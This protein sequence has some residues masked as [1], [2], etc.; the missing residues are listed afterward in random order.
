MTVAPQA[1]ER[2]FGDELSRIRESLS[3]WEFRVPQ[4]RASWDDLDHAF[5]KSVADLASLRMRGAGEH[6]Q[7]PAAGMPWFMAVFG[8][9]TLITCLQTLL[10]GPELAQSALRTL[11]EL[12]ATEDDPSIDAEPGKIVHE[13]RGGKGALAWFP[14]YYGTIDA[15]PLY[16][17]LLSEVWRWTDDASLVRALREPA[18]R[19]LGWIERVRRPRRRRLRRVSETLREGAREPVLE[20]LRASRRSSPT[21]RSPSRRSPRSRCRATSTTRSSA[22]P[23]WRARSGAT[24]RSPSGSNGRRPSSRRA[25]TRRSGSS[26]GAAT[27][28]SRSTGTSGPSTRSART[29]A[30]SSGAASCRPSGS[31]PSSTS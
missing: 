29:W 4:L 23:R 6:G 22:P 16:L 26:G 18:L 5:T 24:E 11:A 28:R 17:I 9:D 25:S 20:G 10:F 31:T 14:R 2:R 13:V 1:A 3:A 19:A 12:Q 30:T 27:T 8:R 7:L 15:T 21:V